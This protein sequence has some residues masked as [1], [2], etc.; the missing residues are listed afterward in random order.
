MSSRSFLLALVLA[1][2]PLA[3][4]AQDSDADLAKKLSNP[5]ASMIS[6]PVQWNY[7][8]CY[9]PSDGERLTVNFQPVVP[10]KLND[11]WNLIVRTIV[12]VVYQESPAPGVETAY[13]LSDVTQ[14]FFFSPR[15]TR[16]G[17][18]WAVGP[19]FLWP[20]GTDELGT[21]KWGAGPTGLV[22]KQDGHATYGVLANHIW[23]YAGEDSRDEVS[24]T[25]LQPFYSYTTADATTWGANLEASYDWTRQAWSVPANLTVS[26]LYKFGEQ[27]VSL[28]VG[29]RLYLVDE[30]DSPDWGVR[31]VATFLFPE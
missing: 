14:S 16:N 31:A 30:G 3:V 27:R 2:H 22:L 17:I 11:D 23:S 12:P 25:F 9:G 8:C 4:Q 26:H 5:V 15:E 1:A 20:V 10:F 24:S 29:V 28:G 18:T 6:V 13:G 21:Q 19:A 7:D